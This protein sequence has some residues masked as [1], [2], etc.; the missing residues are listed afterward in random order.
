MLLGYWA[1]NTRQGFWADTV[2]WTS[3]DRSSADNIVWGQDDNIVWGQDN[4]V[5]GQKDNIVWGQSLAILTK[6]AQ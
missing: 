1:D 2:N 4:I 6:G 5:W 3:V